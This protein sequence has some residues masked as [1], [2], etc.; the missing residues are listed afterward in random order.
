MTSPLTSFDD[1]RW[2]SFARHWNLRPGTTYLNHGSFGP[3]PDLVRAERLRWIAELDAQPMD[4]FVRQFEPAWLA[5]RSALAK[6]VGTSPENLIFVENATVGMNVVAD[7]FP[8]HVGD[9]VLLT[10]HEYG[11]VVRI[12]QRACER[13]GAKLAT[14]QIPLPV[15]SVEETVNAIFAAVNDRTRMIVVS[16]I[17]SPTAIIL[18][19]KEICDRARHRG[20]AVCIDGPHAPA[21]IPVDI[22]ALGCDFYAASCH[23][24][25][26]A[27]FGSGFLFVAPQHQNWVR[28]PTLS[29]GR[30]PPTKLECWSDEFCWSGTRDSSPYLSIPA[31][32]AFMQSV[33]L[34][35]FQSGAH[36]LARYARQR[37]VE[38]TDLE[39]IVPDSPKWYGSMVHVPLPPGEQAPLQN[40]LWQQHCIEVPIVEFLGRRY[41]RVSCHL[42]NTT[43][44]I[45]RLVAALKGL[46]QAGL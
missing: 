28:P 2:V 18:P 9:E 37:L 6:F 16:H 13:Q 40:A 27:P 14:A 5:A 7:S 29:W 42:Y 21:Q 24:W 43:G 22:A 12:W 15:T 34:E 10:D 17:T 25:L 46:L 19:V 39:P 32:I 30:I 11:A 3:P 44:Q 41:I 4:F 36:S 20:I 38:L 1:A 8:L 26:C 31:A 23:K 45:D 35:F 33:G